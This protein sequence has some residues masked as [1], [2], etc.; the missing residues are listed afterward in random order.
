MLFAELLPI[1]IFSDKILLNVKVTPNASRNR[2]GS[3]FNNSLKIY[4]TAVAENGQANKFVLNLLAEKLR[5]NK[6]SL[7]ITQGATTQQKIVSIEGNPD[8]IVKN[9]QIIIND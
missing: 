7:C 1:K 4:V 9:L 3:I 2:I 5:I 8:S 6:N